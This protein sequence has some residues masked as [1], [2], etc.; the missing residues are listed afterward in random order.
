METKMEREEEIQVIPWL[1]RLFIPILLVLA[2]AAAAVV[3]SANDSFGEEQN[4]GGVT[5]QALGC[6]GSPPDPVTGCWNN[7][8]QK[9]GICAFPDE[10]EGSGVEV[11]S[12]T[13]CEHSSNFNAPP[14]CPDDGS[15]PRCPAN[16]ELIASDLSCPPDISSTSVTRD[17]PPP[18][19]AAP[20]PAGPQ[21][22]G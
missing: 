9:D 11:P 12:A 4:N 8:N 20:V 16:I 18:A 10:D 6:P 7:P 22:T 13:G 17:V 2:L 21:F 1:R 3:A 14:G 19:P 5:C 15:G